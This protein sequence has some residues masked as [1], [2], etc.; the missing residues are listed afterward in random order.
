M[1]DI[2]ESKTALANQQPHLLPST[3][4]TTSLSDRLEPCGAKQGTA[5]LMACL[6]LVAPSGMTTEDRLAWV[7]VAKQTLTGMPA[8][9]L[10]RGCD[11]AR[12]TCRF[13]SEIVPTIIEEAEADWNW[14]KRMQSEKARDAMPR[15]RYQHTPIPREETQRIIKEAFTQVG[16][17]ASEIVASA[18]A[19]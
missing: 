18:A 16:S 2:H 1:S 13:A 9:L 8:D 10:A 7:A 5:E 6:T 4:R 11:K 14:R 12:R 15:L 3:C 17:A 19:K